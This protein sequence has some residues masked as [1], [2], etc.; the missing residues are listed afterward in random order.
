LKKPQN[1]P[2]LREA[3]A[4]TSFEEFTE[5]AERREVRDFVALANHRYMCWDKVRSHQPKP[6]ELNA[7]LVWA[8]V[9]WSRHPLELP[10]LLD[11]HDQPFAYW[12]PDCAQADLHE[13]DM[14]MGGTVDVAQP[15]IDVTAEPR[16]LIR[17]LMEEA[18]A[19]S[20][21]EGAV[22]TRPE[23][24]KMLREGRE[25]R[26]Q[27]EQMI[28]NNY[29]TIRRISD[30]KDRP[31]SIEMLHE[32]Q[33]LITEKTLDKPDAAGRFRKADERVS[34]VYDPTGEVLH[35]PPAAETLGERM[36]R[37]CE[38]A[39][40]ETNSPFVHPVIKAILLHFW[41]GYDHPY[42]DGNGRT[43]R[44]LFYWYLLRTG[45]WRFQYISI[46]QVILKMPTQYAM[47]YLNTETDYNDLTYFLMFNLKAIN[48]AMIALNEYIEKLTIETNQ[49]TRLLQAHAQ[50]NLRQRA[51]ISHAIRHPGFTYTIESHMNSNDI[52]YPTA[53]SDLLDLAKKGYLLQTKKK[54]KF[55]FM[56]PDNLRAII[57][58][59]RQQE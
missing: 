51:L 50:L 39:N 40:S 59:G 18:T 17:N 2:K 21:I 57:E 58:E 37:L 45:Y 13:I 26:D 29:R 1:P 25:A 34:V 32:L 56:P 19:S 47:A 38:F 15:G 6:L 33:E 20:R 49:M 35:E 55:I 54:R 52:T 41:V 16:Y 3:V 28:L 48:R 36:K 22:K 9:D 10:M 4:N 44:A 31:L 8:L 23:A 30:L 24:I 14:Q 7:E 27:S 11:K 42:Y 53:R 43:A 46:S 12:L 5:L